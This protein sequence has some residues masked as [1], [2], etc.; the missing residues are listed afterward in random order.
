MS[1]IIISNYLLLCIEWFFSLFQ[2]KYS[3]KEI[4]TDIVTRLLFL[5]STMAIT[6]KKNL[7]SFKMFVI[8]AVG[9][10][11]TQLC[12]NTVEMH[13]VALATYLADLFK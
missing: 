5:L 9:F 13:I 11:V 1:Y 10:Y 6:Y 3:R 8:N 12:I 4:I 7:M 2:P